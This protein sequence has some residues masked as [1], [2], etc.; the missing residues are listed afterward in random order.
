MTEDVSAKTKIVFSCAPAYPPFP[1]PFSPRVK[2]SA[3]SLPRPHHAAVLRSYGRTRSAA[4]RVAPPAALRILL[5][6]STLPSSA[7]GDHAEPSAGEEA[8]QQR[9][10]PIGG[11]T[12]VPVTASGGGLPSVEDLASLRP[13]V[14][15][16]SNARCRGPRPHRGRDSKRRNAVHSIR[17]SV[18]LCCGLGLLIQRRTSILIQSKCGPFVLVILPSKLLVC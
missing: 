4:L 6:I 10:R 15:T 2:I 7:E 16:R 1:F 12:F 8:E 5:P 17:G 3:A 13:S 14:W 9:L 18:L 11:D